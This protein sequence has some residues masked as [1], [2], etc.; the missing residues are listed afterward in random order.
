MSWK[1]D[2][3]GSRPDL[4]SALEKEGVLQDLLAQRPQHR[5]ER[6]ERVL[7][8]AAER[9]MGTSTEKQV[10]DPEVRKLRLLQQIE[11][12]SVVQ[13]EAKQDAI[14]VFS[15]DGRRGAASATKRAY[16]P[17]SSVLLPHCA[18]CGSTQHKRPSC[19]YKDFR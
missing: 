12:S 4:K 14:P 17:S 15:Q 7:L 1:N 13:G 9:P 8:R 3:L 19:P 10:E 6:A 16:T 18:I 2:I 11:A 5:R